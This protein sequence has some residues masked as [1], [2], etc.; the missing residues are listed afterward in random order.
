MSAEAQK[1]AAFLKEAH[2]SAPGGV[3]QILA[4]KDLFA[5]G[6]MD[7]LLHLAL[8][9]FMEAEFGVRVPPLHVSRKTFL[10]VSAI[11]G[12]LHRG[13]AGK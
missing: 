11:E 2:P 7:S 3:E 12:L 6:W 13:P 9:G 8:L 5:D 1:I 4:S 10:S